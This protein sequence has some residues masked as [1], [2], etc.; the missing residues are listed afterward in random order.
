MTTRINHRYQNQTG[1]KGRDDK[2]GDV[3]KGLGVGE[4]MMMYVAEQAALS[5]QLKIVS[6]LLPTFLWSLGRLQ[7]FGQRTMIN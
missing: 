3:R 6:G 5:S 4:A 7:A 1:E 2:E